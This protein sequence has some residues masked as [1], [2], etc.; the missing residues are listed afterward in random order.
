MAR[1][2]APDRSYK[3]LY[4]ARSLETAFGETLV[5]TLTIPYVLSTAVQAR[6][7]SE[8]VVTRTLRLY[9]FLDAGVSTHGLSFAQLHGD[10]YA[11]TWEVSGIIHSSTT[12]DGILY[13][14]RFDN[15]SCVALFDRAA[16]AIEA[17]PQFN[18]SIGAAEATSLAH[19]SEETAQVRHVVHIPEPAARPGYA[20]P[21]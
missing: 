19:F 7:R 3:V 20:K 12:A 9:P 8:I 10:A 13:T 14:S 1:F 18:I 11:K 17:A 16:D 21:C 4:A 15:Q 2:D 5:R 6:A